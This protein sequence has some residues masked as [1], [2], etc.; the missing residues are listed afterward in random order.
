MA[1][2]NIP[3][4]VKKQK[5]KAEAA[6]KKLAEE[7]NK[8]PENKEPDSEKKGTPDKAAP[9]QEPD[10]DASAS[11]V[12]D[13]GTW[14]QR[15]HTLKGKYD[16]EVSADVVQLQ[17]TIN[18]LQNSNDELKTQLAQANAAIQD[19]NEVITG[20]Q[21]SQGTPEAAQGEQ[22]TSPTGDASATVIDPDKGPVD[23]QDLDGWG[24]EMITM[25]KQINKL[26]QMVERQQQIIKDLIQGQQQVITTQQQTEE[27]KFWSDLEKLVPDCQAINVDPN[28]VNVW[29]SKVDD[30]TG[31]KRDVVLQH[32]Y[33]NKDIPR[34]AKIFNAYK[35]EIGLKPKTSTYSAGQD[36]GNQVMP[37]EGGTAPQTDYG[38]RGGPSPQDVEKASQ[39]YT[40]GKITLD[41]YNKIARAWQ[42]ANARRAGQRAA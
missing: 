14:E 7:K 28:F 35:E 13:E 1:D 16:M 15:Y 10:K 8:A 23:L 3:K 39:D 2:E 40:K 19:L 30:A 26:S 41:E 25:G 32:H 27:Q 18:T 34:I 12:G 42:R 33:A 31:L 20:L 24:E 11:S 21:Q 37:A 22:A 17:E 9:P 6:Q 38:D 29:L 5:A 36:M 4:A